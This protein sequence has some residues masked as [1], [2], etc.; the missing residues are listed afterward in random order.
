MTYS[1]SAAKLQ[2]YY[3]C[4]QAY[5]FRY[6]RR[7]PGAAFFSSA[8]LG[9][10]LHQ[11]LAQIYK[12]WHYQD[13]IPQMDWIEHCWSQQT[14]DL[15]RSQ[16]L[17]GRTILRRYYQTF[18]AT[19]SSLRRPLAVEG[20]IQGTLHVENVEFVLSGRYDRLDYLDDGLELIDYK[21]SKETELIHPDE[22]DLQIGL[23]FL[24][25]EQRYQRNLKRLS[26]LYLRTGEKVSFDVTP[27]HRRQV[28]SLIG[29]L[30]IQLRYDRRWIPFPGDQCDR[31]AYARYC[32][33]IHPDDAEP[34][35]EDARQEEG[36]QLTLSL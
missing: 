28:E 21:S 29:D 22:M 36:L 17:E 15:S 12:D 8:V 20:R 18:I 13:P 2:A 4:P 6:E 11:A 9:T 30:A 23:Y 14:K 31:C 32:P 10:S 27:N 35:P 16:V 5:Y 7:L 34:L 3:R 1:L 19:Q 26:L 24:A 33:A 25:L